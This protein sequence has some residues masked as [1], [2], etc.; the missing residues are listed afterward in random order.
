MN[1]FDD[2]AADFINSPINAME[3]ISEYG[4]SAEFIQYVVGMFKAMG[5][6][7]G[8]GVPLGTR[9]PMFL[10]DSLNKSQIDQNNQEFFFDNHVHLLL[11]HV[12]KKQY[13]NQIY[14]SYY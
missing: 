11:L 1:Q 4:F 9:D 8:R 12:N 10:V 3:S 5:L 7:E 14:L 6:D 2:F 13:L